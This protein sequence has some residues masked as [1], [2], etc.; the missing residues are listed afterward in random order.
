MSLNITAQRRVDLSDFGTGWDDCFLIVKAMNTK[1]LKE[2]QDLIKRD[3]NDDDT[4][5]SLYGER[6][7]LIMTGGVIM[8]TNEDGVEEKYKVQ[9]EDVSDVVDAI[10][11]VYKQRALMIAAGTYGLKGI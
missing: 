10:G 2:W 7:K 4:I 8:N 3:A 1:D 11:P 5:D 9:P 6:L